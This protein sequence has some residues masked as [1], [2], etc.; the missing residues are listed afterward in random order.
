[1]AT[2][3]YVKRGKAPRKQTR[4]NKKKAN[5]TLFPVKWAITAFVL[6]LGLGSGLYSLSKTPEPEKTKTQHTKKPENINTIPPK[7]KEKWSYIERLENKE[8]HVEAKEQ[9]ISNRPYLMQCG[10]YKLA[11]QANERKAM[12]AFQ[13]LESH[14][15]KNKGKT[16]FWHR[17]VLGPYAFKREAERDRNLLR[18]NGIEPCEIWFWE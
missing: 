9:E 7:P 10:A 14:I 11:S 16:G 8:I 13:G 17:V 2:R 4:N 12:I 15:K 6:M 1:M 18:R 3:D 5:P